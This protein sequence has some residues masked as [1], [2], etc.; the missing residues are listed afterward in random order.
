MPRNSL[1]RR[2]HT[3]ITPEVLASLAGRYEAGEFWVKL[4][5]V[6]YMCVQEVE[7]K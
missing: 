7:L 6:R 3:E 1:L 4:A 5:V 2:L